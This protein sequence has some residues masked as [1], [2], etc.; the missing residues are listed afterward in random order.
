MAPLQGFAAALGRVLAVDGGAGAAGDGG[1]SGVGGQVARRGKGGDVADLQQYACGG[2]KPGMEIRTLARGCASRI[3]STC[4][5]NLYA[6]V[7]DRCQGSREAWQDGL[8]GGGTRDDD[9]LGVQRGQDLRDEAPGHPGA[10]GLA[11]A[12]SW[13]RPA[14]RRPS[15]AAV[16]GEEFQ[17]R[18]V[19][20]AGPRAFSRASWIVRSRP[21]IRLAS[22]VASPAR[23]SSNPT[24]TSSSARLVAGVDPAQRVRQGMG[25]GGDHEGVTGVGLGVPRGG[26]RRAA[27]WSGQAGR[28]PGSRWRGPPRPAAL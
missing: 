12:S 13:S 25:G 8:G 10:S 24:R 1:E 5:A 22:R 15:G 19:V 2:H 27:S 17:G 4:P 9:R 26:C 3:S 6:L 11:V 7:M 16:A 21:R 28:R 23:S 18:A 20:Q 14:L